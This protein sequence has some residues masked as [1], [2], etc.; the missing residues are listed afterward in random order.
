LESNC[1]VQPAPRT[2]RSPDDRADASVFIGDT[3]KKGWTAE[4]AG[5]PVTDS[6]EMTGVGM[7]EERLVRDIGPGLYRNRNRDSCQQKSDIGNGRDLPLPRGE[8]VG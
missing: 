7:G 6:V 5:V 4:T 8:R 2:N 3:P 1:Q